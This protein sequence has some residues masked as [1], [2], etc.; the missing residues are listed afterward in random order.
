M[1]RGRRSCSIGRL[2]CKGRAWRARDGM[3]RGHV[4]GR[5]SANARMFAP[6][7]APFSAA[8]VAG[9]PVR[10]PPDAAEGCRPRLPRLRCAICGRAARKAVAA[11]PRRAGR[12]LSASAVS[13]EIDRGTAFILVPVFL[14]LGAIVYFSLAQRAGF[15]AARRRQRSCLAPLVLATRSRPAIHLALAALLLCVLGTALAKVETWRAGTK[16]LGGEI[17]TQLTGRVAAIEHHR[18]RP[19]PADH[20]CHRHRQGRCCATRP[21][22][23]A[24]RRARF[25]P[26]SRRDRLVTGLVR[27]MPPSGP[28][29][30]DSYDF[31]FESYFDGIGASG[32]FLRGPQ[33]VAS[34]PDRRRLRPAFHA[35]VERCAQRHRRRASATASAARKAR[36]RRRLS[37]AFAPAFPRR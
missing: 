28:V 7:V 3:A 23:C 24:S 11:V 12:A 27:L 32:F 9:R 1:T 26:A 25:P 17:S 15:A 18:Q 5:A 22:A 13:T 31:S 29:R 30:P 14:A 36:S 33:L 6:G 2:R 19:R 20:R 21:T 16:M 35:S 4:A 37:S 34:R 8:P 10:L